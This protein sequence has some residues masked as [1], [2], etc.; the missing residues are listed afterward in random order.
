MNTSC[1]IWINHV[2]HE[3][4]MSHMNKS[5]RIWMSHVK[6]EEPWLP[7]SRCNASRRDGEKAGYHC[8]NFWVY[9]L[10]CQHATAAACS[11]LVDGTCTF[12][13]DMTHSYA[14]WLIHDPFICDMTHSYVTWRIGNFWVYLLTCQHVTAA[15][16]SLL[17]D[18][19]CAMYQWGRS[20]RDE[21]WHIWI[22][23]VQKI[24]WVTT[25]K[26][27]SCHVKISHYT[28]E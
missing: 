5:C 9:L 1:R 12:V 11:L 16:C 14:T 21:S 27:E 2:I 20:C 26:N 28:H 6:H 13:R 25:H 18:D 3:W 15:A 4:V 7:Q 24:E 17:V 19:T 22:S 10:T 23:N 8:R